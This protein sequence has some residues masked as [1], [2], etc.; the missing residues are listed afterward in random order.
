M[1]CTH[2]KQ[3]LRDNDQFCPYCG[4]KVE[5]CPYCHKII[6]PHSHYC[7]YCGEVLNPYVNEDDYEKK[8]DNKVNWLIVALSVIALIVCSVA[9]LIYLSSTSVEMNDMNQ[10][11][12]NKS[13]VIGDQ[14]LSSTR[15]GNLNLQGS[16]YSSK[17]Y[18]Y[19]CDENGYLIRMDHDLDNRKTIIDES[20]SYVQIV[21]DKIYYVDEK[22]SLCVSSIDGEN[23]EVLLAKD[24]YYVIY[25]KGYIYYQL[26]EDNESIYCYNVDLKEHKKLNDQKSYNINLVNDYI[27]YTSDD[28]I[29]RMN[30]DGQNNKRLLELEV[31]NLIYHDN[32]LY[33][34]N[35]RHQIVKYNIESKKSD[36][37][38][39][40]GSMAFN[41]TDEYLFYVGNDYCV[42]SYDLRT[43]DFKCIYNGSAKMIQ[44]LDDAIVVDT[45]SYNQEYKIII[46]YSGKV[47]V[48]LFLENDENFI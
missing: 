39:N 3:E 6:K 34:S 10:Q 4:T 9:G 13:L 38:A 31:Y 41:V 17:D 36:I 48:R 23:R 11:N 19:I 5:L 26:D 35:G 15:N 46:D 18:I 14:Y 37:I 47:Q 29:Y 24:V 33:F 44:V 16:V 25:E 2:C 22:Q 40:N 27:Y 43:K 8:D 1:K 7:M 42:Y 12:N 45:Y 30:K 28:G 21:E 20:C 32:D